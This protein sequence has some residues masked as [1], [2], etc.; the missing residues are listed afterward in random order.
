MTDNL[1]SQ[2]YIAARKRIYLPE[3]NRQVDVHHTNQEEFQIAGI[4][5]LNPDNLSDTAFSSFTEECSFHTR[6]DRKYWI[7]Y[8]YESISY[9]DKEKRQSRAKRTMIG[10]VDKDTGDIAPTD[11]RNRKN[12]LKK[13]VT[14]NLN[15]HILNIRK[16]LSERWH[17][18][19]RR[20]HR[21]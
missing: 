21:I 8:A 7:T 13:L 11:G 2:A 1:E 17:L 4:S 9:K 10:R 3:K 20:D 14:K 15:D 12:Q 6:R 18:M 19:M 5:N 16:G